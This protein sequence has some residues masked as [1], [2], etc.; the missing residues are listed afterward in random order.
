MSIVKRY[1]SLCED[2]IKYGISGLICGCAGSYYGVYANE[3]TY[4]V[5]QGDFSKERFKLLLYTNIISIIAMTLRGTLFSHS[6]N[7]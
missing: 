4:N 7:V 5:M 1:L 3:H 6:Q 2:D